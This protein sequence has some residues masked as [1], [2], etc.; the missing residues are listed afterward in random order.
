MLAGDWEAASAMISL[1]VE[2]DNSQPEG[3]FQ[4]PF[5]HPSFKIHLRI[6]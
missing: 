5:N 3:K 6:L 4:P 1:N 2:L